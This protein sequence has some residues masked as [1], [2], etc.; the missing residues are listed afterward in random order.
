VIR[1]ITLPLIAPG[2]AVTALFIFTLCW[3]EFLMALIFTRSD[4]KTIPV[5]IPEL[6]TEHYIIW[7]EMMAG[8]VLATIPAIIFGLFIRKYLIRGLTFGAIKG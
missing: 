4:A 1:K 5:M 2:I 7:G 3:N 6:V 8:A